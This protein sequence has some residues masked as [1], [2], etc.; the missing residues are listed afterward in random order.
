MPI[1]LML[2]AISPIFLLVIAYSDQIE[3]KVVQAASS[4]SL[5]TTTKPYNT[6]VHSAITT[7]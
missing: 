7:A 1:E 6:R 2:L 5:D 3:R 4:F